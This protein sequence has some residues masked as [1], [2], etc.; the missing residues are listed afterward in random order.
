[1]K[2]NH[3]SEINTSEDESEL[4]ITRFKL[5]SAQRTVKLLEYDNQYLI[6]LI[7]DL[8]ENRIRNKRIR[9][10]I[11]QLIYAFDAAIVARIR[12][13]D[14]PEVTEPILSVLNSDSREAILKKIRLYD[15][16]VNFPDQSPLN[17]RMVY[18]GYRLFTKA[19]KFLSLIP[20]RIAIAIRG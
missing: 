15:V 5:D 2:N 8:E 7:R 13:L 3:N 10:L 20:L 6:S 16:E 1:M 18:G 11:R 17:Y 19:C 12:H 9:N 14:K 4:I